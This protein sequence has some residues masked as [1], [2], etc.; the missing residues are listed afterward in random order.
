MYSVNGIPLD[1]ETFGWLFRAPSKPLSEI[2]A[3]VGSI[4]IPGRSGVLTTE[5]PID[6]PIISLMVQTSRANLETLYAVFRQKNG[7]LSLTASSSREV[8]FTYMSASIAGYGDAESIIDVTFTIRLDGA[9][10]RDKTA[11]TSTAVTLSSSVTA[12]VFPG[13][14]APIEDAL[15]RLTGPFTSVQ[16][17]DLGS[18]SDSFKYAHSVAAGSAL[19]YDCADQSGHVVTSGAWSGGSDV[20]G[21]LDYYGARFAIRPTFITD[22]AT[23]AGSLKVVTAGFTSASKIEVRGKGAYF[24]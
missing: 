14:S 6:A 7:V 2:V 5:S 18:G 3:G 9:F 19:L 10:W 22:P 23:R 15:V 11:S 1:N 20:S 13:S 8:G 4:R 12:E 16:V 21:K 17:T 24:V